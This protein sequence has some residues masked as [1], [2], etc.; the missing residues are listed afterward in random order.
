MPSN[1][2]Q[3]PMGKTEI[4]LKQLAKTMGEDRLREAF[5]RMPFSYGTTGHSGGVV[6]PSAVTLSIHESARKWES[7]QYDPGPRR[8]IVNGS[9]IQM[10]DM[11]YGNGGRLTDRRDPVISDFVLAATGLIGVGTDTWAHKKV[12]PRLAYIAKFGQSQEGWSSN[13]PAVATYGI[14]TTKEI[15]R[16][17][18]WGLGEYGG[19]LIFD[20]AEVNYIGVFQK[21]PA[22]PPGDTDFEARAL[23]PY[24]KPGESKATFG[25]NAKYIFHWYG[26]E[27]VPSLLHFASTWVWNQDSKD[28]K[29]R[30]DRRNFLSPELG[31]EDFWSLLP[32]N[33]RSENAKTVLT[34]YAKKLHNPS[35]LE[36][37]WNNFVP[38]PPDPLFE[39]A[40]RGAP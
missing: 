26:I 32:E 5:T 33:R 6:P 23:F 25:N 28:A 13:D 11:Y 14:T 8:S 22:R 3:N 12:S 1:A 16:I 2:V 20:G 21:N 31:R 9:N 29:L 19:T 17:I 34:D 7:P 37:T 4:E 18:R 38:L 35:E 39:N 10:M 24:F 27:T 36:P 40:V 30:I 15:S